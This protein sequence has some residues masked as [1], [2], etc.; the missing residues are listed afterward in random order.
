MTKRLHVGCA[1]LSKR[2]YAGSLSK[3][4]KLWL[5]DRTDVTDEA[6]GAV[7]EHIGIGYVTTVYAGDRPVFEIEVRAAPGIEARSAETSGSARQGESPVT[8]G[9]APSDQRGRP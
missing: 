3:N 9:Q 5:S 8:E 2:I 6:L 7:A 4:G 1:P